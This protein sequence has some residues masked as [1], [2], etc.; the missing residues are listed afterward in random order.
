MLCIFIGFGP[1]GGLRGDENP[2]GFIGI[3]L[4][5]GIREIAPPGLGLPAGPGGSENCVFSQVLAVP[6]ASAAAKTLEFQRF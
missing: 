5:G 1:P 3:G 6:S 2:C 4:P